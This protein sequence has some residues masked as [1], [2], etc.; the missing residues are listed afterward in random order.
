MIEDLLEEFRY[1][2]SLTARIHILL[3]RIY[4]KETDR[5]AAINH[6]AIAMSTFIDTDNDPFALAR[7]QSNL[8]ALLI[9]SNQL[10]EAQELLNSANHIQRNI[11]DRVGLAVT[12]HNEHA[13]IRKIVN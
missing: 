7:T 4:E 6:L 2:S 1:N 5:K 13:L 9:N 8:A 11:G 3:G 10:E 12:M